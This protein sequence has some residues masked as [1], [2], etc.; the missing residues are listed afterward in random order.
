MWSDEIEGLLSNDDL[1]P[2][3]GYYVMYFQVEGP[4]IYNW[5]NTKTHVAASL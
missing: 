2:Y 5:T 1:C 4:S 3:L